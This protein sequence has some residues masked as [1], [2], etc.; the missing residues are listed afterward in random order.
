MRTDD[1]IAAPSLAVR[2]QRSRRDAAAV[3]LALVLGGV[4]AL[5]LGGCA[6]RSR[7]DAA[8]QGVVLVIRPVRCADAAA[9]RAVLAVLDADRHAGACFGIGAQG[10]AGHAAR[11][12]AEVLVRD[13][14]GAVISVL[15]PRAARLRPGERVR[16]MRGATPHLVR[17]GP[18]RGP[19]HR[20]AG[21]HAIY[22]HAAW[23]RGFARDGL[24]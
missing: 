2:R 4:P 11:P 7:P 23:M 16:I 17:I 6:A 3:A 14:A 18:R 10:T 19:P 24:A 12:V 22:H 5:L 13:G 20:V 9:T 1:P 8:G 21:H 15:M